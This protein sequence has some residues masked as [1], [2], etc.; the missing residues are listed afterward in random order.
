MDYQPLSGRDFPRFSGIKSFFRLPI[1]PITENFDVALVGVPFDG[2]TSY[3][4]GARFAPSAVREAS[5][6]GRGYH[7]GRGI[8]L[9]QKLK[10]AD[11]G[12][13][14]TVPIDQAQTYLKIE[15]FFAELA[16][17]KKR[18]VSVGGDHSVTLPILRALFKSLGQKLNLIHFDAHLDTYPAAWGCEYHHGAFLRHA[19]SEGLVRGDRTL[20]IGLRGPLAAGDDLKFVRDNGIVATTIDELRE[21]GLKAFCEKLPQFLDGP[22]YLTFDI[23]CLDPAFAPGTGTPVP[24]GLTTHETQTILR[25][26]KVKNLVGAD[27]VE[28]SP[29]YDHAQVT[30]LAG[31]DT[32]FEILCLMA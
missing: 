17:R 30:A 28:I 15:K 20:Q 25:A 4:P 12:D 31:V 22:T 27:V 14:P 11:V 26:L 9:F 7:W 13:C 29:A 5:S 18:F 16:Q 19:V 3:R 21:R 23:D 24:G 1:A 2:G 32:L 10:I 6:L 8:Q